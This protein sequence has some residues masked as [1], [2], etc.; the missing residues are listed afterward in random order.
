MTKIF[1]NYVNK[2]KI[3][4]EIAYANSLL[5]LPNFQDNYFCKLSKHP[6]RLTE[7][8][9]DFF[10]KNNCIAIPSMKLF[11]EKSSFTERWLLRK[12]ENILNYS[13]QFSSFVSLI[14]VQ[15]ANLVNLDKN[16]SK[17]FET[18][19]TLPDKIYILNS[20]QRL[21]QYA[22]VVLG[23]GSP[24]IVYKDTKILQNFQSILKKEIESLA[25]SNRADLKNYSI[26]YTLGTTAISPKGIKI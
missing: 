19:Y 16:V 11:S 3:S 24:R 7:A 6:E 23:I 26:Y 18:G 1:I 25:K 22:D 12:P 17:Y 9:I 10:T 14:T 21:S 13:N 8:Y 20:D 2:S 4:Q 15:E 5:R